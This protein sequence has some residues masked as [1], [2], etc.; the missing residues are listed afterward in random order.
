MRYSIIITTILF[1]SIGFC[2]GGNFFNIY[3]PVNNAY[4]GDFEFT[5]NHSFL[6]PINDEPI[7][8]FF[9]IDNGA[10]IKV[11][12]KY[13][14]TDNLNLS[15][16]HTRF[17][18]RNSVSAGWSTELTSYN[19]E[20]GAVTGYSNVKPSLLQD[21][22]GDIFAVAT[23]SLWLLKNKLRPVLNYAFDGY[24]EEQGLGVGLEIVVLQNLSLISEYVPAQDDNL[25]SSFSIGGRYSTWSHQFLLGV[26]NTSS[27][28]IQRQLTGTPLE[29]MYLTLSIRRVL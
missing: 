24:T 20:L 27:I 29:D 2:A 1:S 18:H 6:G 19:I 21:R 12:L 28:D 9:G 7:D 8:T 22:E 15:L 17:G 5:M 11:G 25:N 26:T 14:F 16:S 13:L 23:G 4:K 3:S 10:N